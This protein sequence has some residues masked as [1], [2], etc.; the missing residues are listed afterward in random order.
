MQSPNEARRCFERFAAW[1]TRAS[2]SSQPPFNDEDGV[3][4]LLVWIANLLELR[5]CKTVEDLLSQGRPLP[6]ELGPTD[7]V[8]L[9]RFV[10]WTARASDFS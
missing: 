8:F 7:R 6:D 4:E 3:C 1:T 10:A 5:A 2:D 9:Q